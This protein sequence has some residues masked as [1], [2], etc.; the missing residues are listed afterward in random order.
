[1]PFPREV[2]AGFGRWPCTSTTFDSF[3]PSLRID[4]KELT[5]KLRSVPRCSL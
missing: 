5:V 1:M 4:P 3:I 2:T